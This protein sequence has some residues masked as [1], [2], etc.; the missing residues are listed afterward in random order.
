[1]TKQEISKYLVEWFGECWHRPDYIGSMCIECRAILHRESPNRNLFTPAGFFWLWNKFRKHELWTQFWW[2]IE[3]DNALYRGRQ[4]SYYDF[5]EYINY[6]TFP[7]VV[8]E[9]LKERE[10]KDGNMEE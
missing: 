2:W 9:F 4:M 10:A 3:E 5:T 6:E 7:K 1:M 8:Y